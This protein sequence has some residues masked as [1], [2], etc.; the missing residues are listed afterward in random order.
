M[1]PATDTVPDAAN[2]R[3]PQESTQLMALTVNV[4]PAATVTSWYCGRRCRMTTW[5]PGAAW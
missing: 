1:A 2:A 5:P 3:T 4:P